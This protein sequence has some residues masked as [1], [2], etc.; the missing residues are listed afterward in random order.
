MA[1]PGTKQSVM[2]LRYKRKKQHENKWRIHK[3]QLLRGK[4][5]CIRV[6]DSDV[7]KD[8]V[9]LAGRTFVSMPAFPSTISVSPHHLM[10]RKTSKA[11]YIKIKL[12]L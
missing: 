6:V 2:N 11:M 4:N 3:C 7:E 5:K 12:S 1:K 9:A 8:V 10:G